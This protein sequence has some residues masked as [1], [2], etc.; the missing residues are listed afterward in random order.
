MATVTFDC[1]RCGRLMGVSS[2]YLG[3]QVR[4]P[5]CQQVIRAPA[6]DRLAEPKPPLRPPHGI[7]E[8]I[9]EA[10]DDNAGDALFAGPEKSLVEMPPEPPVPNLQMEAEPPHEPPVPTLQVDP[11]APQEPYLEDTTI[12]ARH[13]PAYEA[14]V[15][16]VAPEPAT[17]PG[18]GVNLASAPAG[19]KPSGTDLHFGDGLIA[20]HPSGSGSAILGTTDAVED[21]EPLSTLSTRTGLP[22]ASRGGMLVPT[23]LIFLIPYS[24]VTTVAII[25]LYM[26]KQEPSLEILPDPQPNPKSGGPARRNPNGGQRVRIDLKVPDNLA[27]SLRQTIAV[28]DLV[29][30]PQKVERLAGNRLRLT[31]SMQNRSEDVE[32]NPVCDQYLKIGSYTYLE[33]LGKR[34]RIYGG[35]WLATRKSLPFAGR[36]GPGEEMLVQLTTNPDAARVKA[37]KPADRL[38]WRLQVRRGFVQVRGKDVSATAVIGVEFSPRDM[39][40]QE[41]ARLQTRNCLRNCSTFFAPLLSLT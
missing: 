5:H 29:V 40:Q 9:F 41:Q 21:V 39:D 30:V 38:L 11:A 24:L 14:T 25:L 20:G 33:L 17:V 35:Q 8:S 6:A 22:R 12:P 10:P 32:F 7:E 28:G 2:E 23:L 31:L 3:Q 18:S 13:G 34:E 27:G 19:E 16:Y 1:E 4:C 36:L 26:K 15:T 37:I